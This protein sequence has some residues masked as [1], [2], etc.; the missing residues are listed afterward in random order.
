MLVLFSLVFYKW[1][2][3]NLLIYFSK[4]NKELCSSDCLCKFDKE[5]DGQHKDCDACC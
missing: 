3:P 4:I 2:H 1:K 5:G